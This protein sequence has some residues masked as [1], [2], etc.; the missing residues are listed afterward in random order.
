MAG[1]FPYL[2]ELTSTVSLFYFFENVQNFAV[3]FK[4][5]SWP[6]ASLYS[7]EEAGAWWHQ[8]LPNVT[9]VNVPNP[10]FQYLTEWAVANNV[11]S[12]RSHN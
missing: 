4:T 2:A 3:N 8:A 1:T 6:F 10:T 9:N 11:S 12:T 5:P 7:A